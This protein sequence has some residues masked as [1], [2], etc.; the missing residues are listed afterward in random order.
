MYLNQ[1]FIQLQLCAQLLKEV[2]RCLISLFTSNRSVTFTCRPAIQNFLPYLMIK[3]KRYPTFRN[4][5]F[6][7]LNIC[8]LNSLITKADSF[9][10]DRN[11]GKRIVLICKDQREQNPGSHDEKDG[12]TENPLKL[13]RPMSTN[14]LR[15]RG[16][17]VGSAIS[18]YPNKTE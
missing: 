15:T 14:Y 9:N 12:R 2:D 3:F 11:S 8:A 7:A 10:N 1:F 18:N 17:F 16:P 5:R 4:V 6:E 13:W